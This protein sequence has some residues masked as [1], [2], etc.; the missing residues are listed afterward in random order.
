M[1]Y[2]VGKA[3]RHRILMRDCAPGDRSDH[4]FEIRA[5]LTEFDRRAIQGALLEVDAEVRQSATPGGQAVADVRGGQRLERRFIELLKR[6]IVGWS[7][8]DDDGAAVPTTEEWYAQLGP[9]GGHMARAIDDYYARV[10][11]TEG[12]RGNSDAASATGTPAA[13]ASLVS[14]SRL[15]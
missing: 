4:W 14:A 8:T 15:S 13:A 10:D 3:A 5:G 2:F 6:T 12:E 1:S 11:M 7:F 9:A